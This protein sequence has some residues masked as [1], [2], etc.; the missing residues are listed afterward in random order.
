MFLHVRKINEMSFKHGTYFYLGTLPV[1]S[2]N[3]YCI[4]YLDGI[5]IS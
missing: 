1:H 5:P 4:I 3:M 2:F